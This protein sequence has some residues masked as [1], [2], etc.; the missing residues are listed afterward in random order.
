MFKVLNN[1]KKAR[2]GMLKTRRGEIE[3]PCF[4]P[5]ATR[6]VLKT[7]TTEDLNQLGAQ[8]IL[9]N[10]YHLMLR[11]GEKRTEKTWR[12]APF[13]ELGQADSD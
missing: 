9:G 1:N 13:Y 2:L 10:T 8:I 7:L 12:L 5:I 4:M 6:G 11:P 3:T